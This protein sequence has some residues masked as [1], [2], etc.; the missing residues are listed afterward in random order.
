MSEIL[1]KAISACQE[2][3]LAFCKFIAAN[4]VGATGAHQSGIY[5]PKSAYRILFDVAGHKGENK[6]SFVKIKWQDDF[7]TESRFIWYGKGTR[8]EYRITRF[9]RG[10]PFL[11]DKY[12]GDL[13]VLVK[14]N[15]EDYLAFIISSDE[16]I[17][18]FL[19]A[20]GMSPSDTNALI[21]T[22]KS[23]DVKISLEELFLQYVSR[24]ETDFPATY[25]I[26]KASREIYIKIKK[27][28]ILNSA[29]KAL[30]QWLDIEYQLFRAI[31]N[32]RYRDRI[33][34]PFE[35]VDELI[36]CANTLLN[37]RKSR[38]GRSLEHHL[39]A[40]F[41]HY[42]LS[43]TAQAKTEGNKKPDFIFPS[44]EAYHDLSFES[45]GLTFLGA[46]TTCKD[47][48]RQILNEADRIEEKHL[49][50]L[51]QG[52]SKNQLAEM[53]SHKVTL[54]VPKDYI[55]SFPKE[56]KERIF[57]LE[58]FIQMVKAKNT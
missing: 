34:K 51:Q 8:S 10:F 29:D 42:T 19:A 46:K 55:S 5:I 9:G 37:R 47:R 26:A 4:D 24:L 40:M 1:E 49:F 38:A 28:K 48:W 54:V 39:A 21:K 25:E 6:D 27:G 14:V 13:F 52:I 7:E 50:T 15:K 18:G 11:K 36:R 30:I 35:T 58:Y 2:H 45:S 44:E 53:Y 33:A 31:E 17:E 57:S 12:M 23:A 22:D 56:F 20:F 41:T 43:Y 32:D 3:P 16:E